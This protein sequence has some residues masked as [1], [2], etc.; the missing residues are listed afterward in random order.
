[1]I[2]HLYILICL[3]WAA[4]LPA[5]KDSIGLPVDRTSVLV[6]R[7]FDGELNEKYSGPE[8]Q[9]GVDRG[10]SMNLISRF[11]HWFLNALGDIFGVDVSPAVLLVLEYVIYTL[12]GALAIYLLVRM[13]VRERFS[14]LFTRKA[15][16]LMDLELSQ[17]HIESLDLDALVE[18]ALG[19]GN[20][21]L[22]VR[23]RFLKI[24]KLLSQRE[25]IQWHFEKTNQ[26]YMEELVHEPLQQEFRKASY[27]FENIW[28]GL[29]PIDEMG[30]H[31][32]G[33]RFDSLNKSMP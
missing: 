21:R 19:E 26:D 17:R 14:S 32:V 9:Y 16:S 3:F 12:M 5:Q 33:H 20:Y 1:M 22:A 15:K 4:A 28:Y 2:R 18:E 23:Y 31:K 29:Q 30:Y 27:L 24:L 13:F 6:Q 10:E 7:Q 25:L 11:I 8:F